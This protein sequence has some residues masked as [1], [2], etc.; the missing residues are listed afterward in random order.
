ML[1]RPEGTCWIL[2]RDGAWPCGPDGLWRGITRRALGGPRCSHFLIEPVTLF[3][4]EG[5]V[6]TFG[7]SGVRV[8]QEAREITNAPVFTF[9]ELFSE[10]VAEHVRM[11][12]L[13]LV[14]AQYRARPLDQRP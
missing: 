10:R 2:F 11:G 9:E 8:P 3:G 1:A 5:G 14:P 6:V 4:D 7:R 13:W 12:L